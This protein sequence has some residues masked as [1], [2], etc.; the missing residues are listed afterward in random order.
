MGGEPV[1]QAEIEQ[2]GRDARDTPRPLTP[3]SRLRTPVS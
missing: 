1:G 2:P 3:P